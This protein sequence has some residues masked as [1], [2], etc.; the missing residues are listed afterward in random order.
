LRKSQTKA[1]DACEDV[2]GGL[3]PRKRL[4]LGVVDIE[5]GTDGLLEFSRRA[6]G[7]TTE[8]AFGER[9]EPGILLC[10]ALHWKD[11]E[12]VCVIAFGLVMLYQ[13]VLFIHYKLGRGRR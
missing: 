11:A 9:R 13:L 6:M 1:L 5:V 10:S 8:V 12:G 2:I 4:W 3:G 7:A